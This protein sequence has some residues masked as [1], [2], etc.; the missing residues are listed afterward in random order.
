M[1]W[2]AKNVRGG[3]TLPTLSAQQQLERELQI[4]KMALEL[5]REELQALEKNLTELSQHQHH[6]LEALRTTLER[7]KNTKFGFVYSFH[8]I[9]TKSDVVS[10]YQKMVPIL[11]YDQF[12]EKWLKESI[13]G[14]KD[15]TWKG[16]IKYYA[17]SL[18]HIRGKAYAL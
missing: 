18:R 11:D 1:T 9:L 15:H 4:Y 13:N 12:Y 6:Q 2:Q 5:Q 17:L 8:S 10:Q 14:V 7:A 16:R 3:K